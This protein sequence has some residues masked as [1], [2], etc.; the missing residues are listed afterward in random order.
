[1]KT[2]ELPSFYEGS[3]GGGGGKPRK[4]GLRETIA[5]AFSEMFSRPMPV[6]A[7][8][9]FLAWLWCEGYKVV[10]LDD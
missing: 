10:P 5:K 1:M 9:L 8:D 6:L 3:G 2:P 7:A 4:D